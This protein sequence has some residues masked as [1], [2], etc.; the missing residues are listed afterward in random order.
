M[1]N[2]KLFLSLALTVFLTACGQNTN[3]DSAVSDETISAALDSEEGQDKAKANEDSSNN[4]T[5]KKKKVG[6]DGI[7]YDM[8][9]EM[10]VEKGEFSKT[11]AKNIS[12]DQLKELILNARQVAD[13]TGY[14]DVKDFV[15]QDLGKTFPE[16]SNKFPL[17]SIEEKYSQKAA[18]P[19]D[20]LGKFDFE[21]Q[22]MIDMG[23]PSDSVWAIDDKK[24]QDAFHQAYEEDE[25]L[26]YEDY[27]ANAGAILFGEDLAEEEEEET[28][29]PKEDSDKKTESAEHNKASTNNTRKNKLRRYGS[30]QT[31][32]DAIKS[33]LVQYYEFSPASVNQMTNEDIDRAYTRAMD[34]LEET[35]FGDI[36]LIYEELG[37]MY[38]GASTMY[39]GTQGTTDTN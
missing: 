8:W 10:I 5:K 21:R 35:G 3:N 13:I 36:G 27:V 29:L 15:F 28:T 14:W 25:D 38:P 2:K 32:Y 37:K 30:S 34:R 24:V 20:Y 39:P 4:T 6:K 11:L 18:N 17:D 12:E 7:D 22:Q 9:R 23:Y 1:N 16:L 19:G 31:D 33:A 26:Y